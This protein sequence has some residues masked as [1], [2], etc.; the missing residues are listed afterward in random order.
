M[1]RYDQRGFGLSEKSKGTLNINDMTGDIVALTAA[2]GM[3]GPAALSVRQWVREL[4]WRIRCTIRS[5][6]RVRF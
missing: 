4:P 5:G 6:W 1:L 2:V 3:N